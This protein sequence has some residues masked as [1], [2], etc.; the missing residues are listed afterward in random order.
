[1]PCITLNA[2][3]RLFSSTNQFTKDNDTHVGFLEDVMLYVIKGFLPMKIIESVWLHRLAYRLCPRVVFPSKNVFV[4]KI[5]LDLVEKTMVTY[6]QLALASCMS[7]T[8]TFDLWMFARTH[9]VFAMVVNLLS[10]FSL[11]IGSLN[12]GQLAYLKPL[13]PAV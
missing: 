5:M 3:S 6:V 12:M 7:T 10:T 13:P 2:I 11:T 9:Y 4:E 8:Y 1:V